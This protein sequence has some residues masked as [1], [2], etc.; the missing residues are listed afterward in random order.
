MQSC[1]EQTEWHRG[2]KERDYCGQYCRLQKLPQSPAP[3]TPG[4]RVQRQV[5]CEDMHEVVAR[6]P[7]WSSLLVK[8]LPQLLKC[9]SHDLGAIEP[10]GDMHTDKTGTYLNY[11]LDL[12]LKP[13]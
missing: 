6:G 5:W 11:S 4:L 1:A 3:R 2:R 12:T 13:N 9:R 7:S 8:E 10:P